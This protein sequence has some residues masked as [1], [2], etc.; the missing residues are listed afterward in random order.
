MSPAR[1]LARLSPSRTRV[2][3]RAL[4]IAGDGGEVTLHQPGCAT[5]R[6]ELR[7][8]CRPL[9]LRVGARA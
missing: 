7:C 6:A 8:D 5:E 9:T 2:L 1:L 3:A 4:A